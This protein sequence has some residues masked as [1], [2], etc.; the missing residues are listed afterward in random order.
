MWAVCVGSICKADWRILSIW[1]GSLYICEPSSS[2]QYYSTSLQYPFS[3]TSAS[4]QHYFNIFR[5]FQ[6][7]YRYLF[8]AHQDPPNLDIS[9][10]TMKFSITVIALFAALINASPVTIEAEA[11]TE[12]LWL[13]EN[14][15]N[16]TQT[17]E[18]RATIWNLWMYEN[19]N[20]RG[21]SISV[22][23]STARCRK[24]T[25]FVPRCVLTYSVRKPSR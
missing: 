5:Y 21:A 14:A 9:S 8:L 13:G 15:D 4:L 19:Q 24:F 1:F 18:A 16:T 11:P 2:L 3:I 20:F 25:R 10:P 12:E 6:S 23:G 7:L 22:K 17:I